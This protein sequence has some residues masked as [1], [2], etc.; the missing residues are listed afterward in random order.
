MFFAF[1]HFF[2]RTR[3]WIRVTRECYEIERYDE[4]A[5]K[6]AQPRTRWKSYTLR[7]AN[8]VRGTFKSHNSNMLLPSTPLVEHFSLLSRSCIALVSFSFPYSSLF[9]CICILSTSYFLLFFPASSFSLFA[10]ATPRQRPE[11]YCQR[12]E[13]MSSSLSRKQ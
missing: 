9:T 1:N 5:W 13:I 8:H 2:A 7:D 10:L 4:Y 3:A 11:R 6:R 12:F